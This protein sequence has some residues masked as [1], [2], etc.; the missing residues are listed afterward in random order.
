MSRTF[1]ALL[2]LTLGVPTLAFIAAALAAGANLALI[3]NGLTFFIV[4]TAVVA[5]LFEIKRLADQDEGAH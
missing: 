1:A 2:V 3:G 4:L 5:M